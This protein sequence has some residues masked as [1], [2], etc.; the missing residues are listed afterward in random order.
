MNSGRL[1]YHFPH[2]PLRRGPSLSRENF[3]WIHGTNI[4]C[5]IKVNI[6]QSF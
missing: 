5:T 6:E 3:V 1:L 4:L 2:D